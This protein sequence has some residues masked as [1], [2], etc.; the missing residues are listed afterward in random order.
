VSKTPKPIIHNRDHEHGGADTVRIVYESVGGAG[1]GGLAV[2][3]DTFPQDAD[4]LAFDTQSGI[5][6]ANHDDSPVSLQQLGNEALHIENAGSG[7]LNLESSGTGGIILE[8]TST[9]DLIIRVTGG[10]LVFQGVPTSDPGVSGAI[11]NNGGV[12]N[13]S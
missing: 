1:G 6:M 11:W 10:L 8:C 13:I 7:Q 9:G 5:A 3:F 12:L 4:Y 2:L